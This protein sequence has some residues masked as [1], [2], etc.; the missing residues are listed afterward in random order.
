MAQPSKAARRDFRRA[1]MRI[2]LGYA[3]ATSRRE[4]FVRR[5][6]A[7]EPPA[8]PGLEKPTVRR[9]AHIPTWMPPETEVL[10]RHRAIEGSHRIMSNRRDSP[11]GYELEFDLGVV[12]R[13][14]LPG[15]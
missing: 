8:L 5:A 14:A 13:F 7:W 12:H 6:V 4:E 3:A 15:T 11:P 1:F 2:R 9:W 10:A